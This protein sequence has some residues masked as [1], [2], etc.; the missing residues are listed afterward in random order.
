MHTVTVHDDLAYITEVVAVFTRLMHT[1]ERGGGRQ[2]KMQ[3]TQVVITLHLLP[4][5]FNFFQ[6]RLTQATGFTSTLGTAFHAH[7]LRTVF[8]QLLDF[9]VRS[10]K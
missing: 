6:Q 2:M 10:Y 8:E 9:R 5:G 7:H 1:Q 4:G 3:L